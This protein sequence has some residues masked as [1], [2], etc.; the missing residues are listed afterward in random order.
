MRE[1]YTC[2]CVEEQQIGQPVKA[3]HDDIDDLNTRKIIMYCNTGGILQPM[4]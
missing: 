4:N 3:R 2:R 1:L